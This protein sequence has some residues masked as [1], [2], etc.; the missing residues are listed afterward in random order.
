MW[1]SVYGSTYII[2]VYCYVAESQFQSLFR[3]ALLCNWIKCPR[4]FIRQSE[5]VT[6]KPSLK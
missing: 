2:P 4:I 3:F 6:N 1:R 5:G